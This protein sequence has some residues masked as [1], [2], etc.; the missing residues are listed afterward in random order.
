MVA[1]GGRRVLVTCTQEG[2]ATRI[3]TL[4]VDVD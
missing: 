1:L 3:L 2:E 4:L